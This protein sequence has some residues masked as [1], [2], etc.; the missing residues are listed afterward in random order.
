[1]RYVAAPPPPGLFISYR[2]SDAGPYARLLK[3]QLSRHLPDTPVFMDLDSIEAGTDFAEAI[4]TGVNSSRVLVALIGPKWLDLL[5]EAGRRRLDD[6]DD[7]VRFEIRTALERCMRVIPVLIDG[8]EMP[9]HHQLPDDLGKLARLNAIQMSYDRYE[10]DECRLITVIQKV[11]A[12]G[13]MP[14]SAGGGCHG[15]WSASAGLAG[16]AAPATRRCG[17]QVAAV[18]VPGHAGQ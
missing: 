16:D 3:V 14:E 11:L 13:K 17:D 8:A 4:Q 10:Y 15:C 7:Y 9:Q 12:A 6:P 1:V 18:H 5:D 2:R